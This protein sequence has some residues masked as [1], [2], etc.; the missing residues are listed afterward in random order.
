MKQSKRKTHPFSG[1]KNYY[2]TTLQ[3]VQISW[4]Y[5][6][7]SHL[8]KLGASEEALSLV[9]GP[10]ERHR[11]AVGEK[12]EVGVPRRVFA[13]RVL[14]H[15]GNGERE[16]TAELG[17]L[18][19]RRGACGAR[20][21]ARRPRDGGYQVALSERRHSAHVESTGL[22]GVKAQQG[23]ADDAVLAHPPLEGA[24]A[25]AGETWRE[26]RIR[27]DRWSDYRGRDS[28]RG[29]HRAATESSMA[30]AAWV[31]VLLWGLATEEVRDWRSAE[32]REQWA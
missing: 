25:T 2:L 22:A 32:E 11:L 3:H 18:D 6:R 9:G 23:A 12:A 1:N 28:A 26:K 13:A 10:H 7:S 17:G 31:S 14:I 27:G 24:E 4:S 5:K 21:E 29:S 8:V 30:A 19:G 15:Y 20:G 16:A